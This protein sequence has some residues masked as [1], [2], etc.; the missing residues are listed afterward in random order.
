MRRRD[1][2]AAIGGVAAWPLSARAQEP[3]RLRRIAVLTA[4]TE[5]DPD[6][7]LRLAAFVQGLQKLGWTDGRNVRLDYRFGAGEISRYHR[8]AVELV[9]LQPDAIL[10]IGTPAAEALRQATRSIPIVFTLVSDP[11]GAGLIESLAHPGGNITGFITTEPP[12]AGKLVQLLK[13]AAPEVKRVAFLYNPEITYAQ[14]WLR[15]AE[16]A[17][18]VYVVQLIA[19]PVRNVAE[20]ES[21]LATLAREPNGGLLVLADDVTW[22]YRKHIITLAERHRFPSISHFHV[23]VEDG[24][25]MSYDANELDAYPSAAGYIDRILKGEKPADLPVQAAVKYQLTINLKSAMA[26]G[27][28]IPETFLVRADKII[29]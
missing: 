20:I 6:G 13:E 28:T 17:A 29:E 26:V 15:Y 24:G 7:Q 21:A 25:L 14:A 2:I 8:F 23:F 4:S 16:A 18:A 5:S 9:G 11:I 3:T 12:L 19:A 22:P 10:A 27:L 1:F